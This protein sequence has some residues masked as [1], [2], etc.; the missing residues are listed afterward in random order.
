MLC[1][2][3]FAWPKLDP[4]C[5]NPVEPKGA[6]L[7]VLPKAGE[8]FWP[9]RE[10]PV[11]LP[12]TEVEDPKALLDCPKPPKPGLEACPK[13]EGEAPNAGVLCKHDSY[14]ICID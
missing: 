2:K 13:T 5:P 10:L 12:K 14:A 9:K 6:L 1:A 3:G 11:G 7:A 8:E 4:V